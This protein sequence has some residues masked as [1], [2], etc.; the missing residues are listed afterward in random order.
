MK[1]IKQLILLSLIAVLLFPCFTSLSRAK[2]QVNQ[3]IDSRQS[4]TQWIQ[5]QNDWYMLD[6]S[7]QFMKNQW[8]YWLHEWYYL[9]EKGVMLKNEWLADNNDWFYFTS[10]GAMADIPQLIDGKLEGFDSRGRWTGNH[11]MYKEVPIIIK[12]SYDPQIIYY[13][14]RQMETLPDELTTLPNQYIFSNEFSTGPQPHTVGYIQ[15]TF[16]DSL[17]QKNTTIDFICI[18]SLEMHESTLLHELTHALDILYRYELS[19]DPIF[20]EAL[21]KEAHII[22]D[23]A[24]SHEPEEYFAYLAT[25]YFQDPVKAKQEYPLCAIYIEKIFQ[26]YNISDRYFTLQ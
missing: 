7:G 12:G 23:K 11:L 4:E 14:I 17:T 8:V 5:I 26:D 13:Y 1:K 22:Q 6:E 15:S 2:W 9:D 19:N 10:S 20:L 21:E 16:K 18:T 3:A 25:D 24:Y